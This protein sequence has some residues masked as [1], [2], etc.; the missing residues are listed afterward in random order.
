MTDYTPHN[1]HWIV[2]GDETRAWSSAAGGYVE[3]W[4]TDAVTRIAS[5]AELTDVLRPY[6]LM[7]PAPTS[8]DYADAVQSH[9]DAVAKSRDYGNGALLASYATS[10][11]PTWAADAAAFVA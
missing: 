6:G 11:I 5:E 1:W 9:V 2:G 4:P 8:Q 7:L 10:T 3:T